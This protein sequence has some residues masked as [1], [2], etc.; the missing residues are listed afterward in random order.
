MKLRNDFGF[1]LIFITHDLSLLLE[2]ADTI[3][4]MYAGRIAEIGTSKDLFRHPRHPYTYGLLNSFPSLRGPQSR[5]TGIPGSPPDL[6]PVQ[7]AGAFHPRCASASTACNPI[8]PARL[9]FM[10]SKSYKGDPLWN[11]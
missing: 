10:L 9:P 5:L 4:I 8:F 6:R 1:S 3:A 2:I 7:P 11:T